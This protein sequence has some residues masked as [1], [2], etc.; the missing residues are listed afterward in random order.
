LPYAYGIPIVT[1]NRGVLLHKLALYHFEV[2]LVAVVVATD[3]VVVVMLN[4]GLQHNRH[5]HLYIGLHQNQA[6]Q[7]APQHVVHVIVNTNQPTH[8]F[9]IVCSLHQMLSLPIT[10]F[11]RCMSWTLQTSSYF[12]Y[13]VY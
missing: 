9:T 8:R 1:T 2:V 6:G 5:H 4:L 3:V 12:P 10:S 11:F 7:Q 13:H